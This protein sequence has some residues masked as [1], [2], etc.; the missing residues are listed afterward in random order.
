MELVRTGK[1]RI[2]VDSDPEKQ[3]SNPGRG[4]QR[5]SK[6]RESTQ[7]LL[8]KVWCIGPLQMGQEKEEINI[9]FWGL[10]DT[11]KSIVLSKI[12]IRT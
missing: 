7:I 1:A 8:K 3:T 12:R 5:L 2:Q 9:V 10:E 4:C 11:Q 6:R